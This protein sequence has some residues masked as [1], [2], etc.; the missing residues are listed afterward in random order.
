MT[1]DLKRSLLLVA[2][3]VVALVVLLALNRTGGGDDEP[4]AATPTGG[5]G[6]VEVP[7]V[8]DDSHVLSPAPDGA[9][10]LVEF[11]DFECEACRAVHP[12]I[13]QL[14]QEY[15]GRVAFVARYMPGPGHF[16]AENA[17]VA[18]EAAAQQGQYEAMYDRMFE[19]QGDWGEQQVSAADLFRTFAGELGLDLAAYDAAVADPATL[20]RVR[21]DLDDGLALGVE[22]TPTFFLDG[23]RIE[24]QSL[25]DL[26]ALL[27]AALAD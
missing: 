21:S 27:D 22:G 20:D 9:P 5:G 23:E 19:T 18:V 8:R 13:E 14:R 1:K 17:A 3:F 6:S 26:R 15:D 10:V 25:D 12:G 2:G 16:N 7:V 24:P 11:L 4:A